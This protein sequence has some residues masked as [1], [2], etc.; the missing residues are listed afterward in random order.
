[1]YTFDFSSEVFHGDMFGD[2]ADVAIRSEP[3][4]DQAQKILSGPGVIFCK[5]DYLDYL[6]NILE[7]PNENQYVLI[8]HN[9]DFHINAERYSQRIH[10]NKWF[11]L[12]VDHI[13]ENLIPIPSG[14][15]RPLGGGYS[16]DRTVLAKRL[17][18]PRVRQNLAY[19]NHN[20]NNNHGARDFITE[21]LKN[22]HWVTWRPHGQSFHD[23]IKN[24]Y[25]HDFVISPEGNGIDCHRTWEALWMGAIPVVKESY[26]TSSFSSLPMLIVEDWSVVTEELLT[27][28]KE[29]YD[30]KEFNYEKLTFSYWKNRILSEKERLCLKSE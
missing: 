8:T 2:I 30:K 1:M 3:T 15:E 21:N 29:E 17:Q 26:L 12:N 27:I 20:A 23:F 22:Q 28:V 5:T 25:E 7:Q 24:C 19:M 13:D 4:M 10:I 11:A 9:S 16:S 14:M 18:E 6:W